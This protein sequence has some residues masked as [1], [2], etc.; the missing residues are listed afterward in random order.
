MNKLAIVGAGLVSPLGVT[1][2][3]HAFHLRAEVAAAAPGG[4]VD[5]EG[6]P[7]RASYCPWLGA[8]APLTAR[9]ASLSMTAL[10]TA[11]EPL[12]GSSFVSA[13]GRIRA[14]L[15][16]ITGALRSASGAGLTDADRM[17]VETEI[18]DAFDPPRAGR[19]IGEASVFATLASLGDRLS[20]GAEQAAVIVAVDSFL[21]LPA[22]AE[23]QR[24]YRS[25]WAADLPR[26]SEGAACVVLML[27]ETARR[28]R[29]PILATIHHAATLKGESNDDNEA[30]I[31]GVALT[32]LLRA[33]PVSNGLFRA[34]F[35][36]HAGDSLR[37]RDWE[38]AAARLPDRVDS[39]CEPVCLEGTIGNVGAASGLASLVFGV[40]MHRHGTWPAPRASDGVFL[41]WAVSPDG[42]RGIATATVGE[43]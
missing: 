43:R 31:D 11:R 24:N 28:E 38:M 14:A 5:E 21:T 16:V 20:R 35:G 15:S 36:P 34:S 2:E 1:P 41:A 25:P 33:A 9:L 37:R 23:H 12:A 10:R 19:G 18:A 42:T 17:A 27:P 29:L 22:L 32:N 13:T 3:E 30:V 40:A 6:E 26:A 8:E 39:T 7:I 4:L